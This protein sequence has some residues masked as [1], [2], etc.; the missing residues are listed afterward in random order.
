MIHRY[1]RATSQLINR[2][3]CS[4]QFD[5]TCP[6]VMQAVVRQE[7]QVQKSKLGKYLGLPTPDGRMHKGK[8]QMLH[9]SLTRRIMAWGD[10]LSQ[11]GKE[12]LIKSVLQAISTYIMGVFNLSCSVCEDPTRLVR[13]FWWGSKH[14]QRKTHWRAWEKIIELKGNG[15][16]GFRDFRIFNQALFARQAF[17]L[18]TRLDSLCS[19]ALKAK[20]YPNGSLE[21]TVFSGNASPTWH[22]I[23]HGLEPLKQRLVWRVGNGES[24]RIWRDPWIPRPMSYR[25]ITVR[26]T[27]RLRRVSELLDNNGRWWVDL[28]QQFF[29]NPDGEDILSIKK[30]AS[31]MEERANQK[32]ACVHHI[33]QTRVFF[34]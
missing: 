32:I 8:F 1:A 4:I 13:N 18:L 31:V 24:I 5:D 16:L 30:K 26:G 22:A 2:Q 17:Q 29:T 6:L 34:F 3:K 19:K 7:L 20:N 10:T 12:T 27:C 15:G 25:P 21:D 28:L 11:L 33:A 14:G 9:A 23:Q